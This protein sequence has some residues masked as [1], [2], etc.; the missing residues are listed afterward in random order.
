MSAT[1]E[2]PY[3]H[4]VSKEEELLPSSTSVSADIL[5]L[6][7]LSVLKP[8]G[9]RLLQTLLI[10]YRGWKMLVQT[11]IPGLLTSELN[12]ITLYGALDDSKSIQADENFRKLLLPLCKQLHI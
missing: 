9:L 3:N 12:S 7:R 10:S 5:N 2:T 11:I 4:K 6:E 1:T 8:K